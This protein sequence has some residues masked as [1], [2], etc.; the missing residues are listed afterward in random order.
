M[1]ANK[2]VFIYIYV[3]NTYKIEIILSINYDKMHTIVKFSITGEIS[4]GNSVTNQFDEIIIAN[5]ESLLSLIGYAQTKGFELNKK[6][7]LIDVINYYNSW[8]NEN[9]EDYGE[10]NDEGKSFMTSILIPEPI[11][12]HFY[13]LPKYA[14]EYL[15]KNCDFHLLPLNRFENSD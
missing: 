15:I 9:C 11:K 13:S 14:R 1:L 7:K 4:L 5:L 2:L 3:S 6:H 8:F 10:L 12:D